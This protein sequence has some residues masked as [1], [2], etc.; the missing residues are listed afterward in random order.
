MGRSKGRHHNAEI[1]AREVARELLINAGVLRP[2]TG[3]HHRAGLLSLAR[4]VFK[5]VWPALMANAGAVRFG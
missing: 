1:R 4:D 3:R 5:V 2:P